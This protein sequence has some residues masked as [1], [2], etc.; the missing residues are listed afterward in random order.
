MQSMVE[1]FLTPKNPSTTAFGGGPP[2]PEIRGRIK[3]ATLS[4]APGIP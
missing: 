1:A 3:E 4:P 2:P